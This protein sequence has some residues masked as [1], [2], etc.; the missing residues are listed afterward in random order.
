MGEVALSYSFTLSDM[1]AN[2]YSMTVPVFM[3]SLTNLANILEKAEHHSAEAKYDLNHLLN[4][5][6][7]RDM[8]PF[9]RQVQIACDTAKG[10]GARLG[11]IDV[12]SFADDEKTA[13][14]L[15]ARIRK[16]VEFLKSISP[17]HYIGAEE[18]DVTL[19]YFPG[20]VFDGFTYATEYA[21]PNFFFH[22]TIAYALLRHNGVPLGKLDYLGS[23]TFRDKSA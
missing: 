20:K 23:L 7:Y 1:K 8:F 9:I 22:V 11:G 21:L 6:L 3:R 18:R 2:L 15:I 4:D 17:D 16:T 19:S 13:H 12:P 10:A 14:E 5:R